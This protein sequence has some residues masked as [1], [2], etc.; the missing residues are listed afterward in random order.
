MQVCAFILLLSLLLLM[1]ETVPLCAQD[2]TVSYG[3]KEL[4]ERAHSAKYLAYPTALQDAA[5]AIYESRCQQ[6]A[7]G[8]GP[9][10]VSA[11]TKVV[12]SP[13]NLQYQASTNTWRFAEN[14]WDVVGMGYGQTNT[15]DYCYIG[16][17]VANSDNRQIGSNYAGWIDLYGWGTG[18]AP[19][20][21]STNGNDYSSFTDWG[22]NP[23]SNGGNKP[24]QWRTLTREEWVYLFQKRP[25]A[26]SKFGAA[27]VNGMTGVVI[28]PDDWTLPAGCGFTPGMISASQWY[29]WSKVP[30]SNV[31]EGTQWE[32]MEQAG[33]V[34]LPC[35]GYR[36]GTSV[37]YVGAGGNYWSSTQNSSSYTCYLNFGSIYL[38]PEDECNRSYGFSVRL[39]AGL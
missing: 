22:V 39:V 35:A 21:S 6:G 29:D 18:N 12:F 7:E 8:L 37:D 32:K 20:K 13:G 9:F 3:E 19:T 27:K 17:T 4:P 38:Y 14:Q 5:N 25:N 34:F 16:G 10:S 36:S 30:T 31:Y 11:T 26:S 24:N 2:V 15:S 1:P 28:L 23:I 33:A